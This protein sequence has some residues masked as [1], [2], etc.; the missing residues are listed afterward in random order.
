M[1]FLQMLQVNSIS[2]SYRKQCTLNAISF[3]LKSGENLSIVGESGSGKSTLL[4][5]IYGLYDLNE[6]D[7]TWN[8]KP[9]LG[10]SHNL[11]VGYDFMKYVAQDLNIMPFT[12]VNENIGHYLSNFYPKEKRLRTKELVAIVGLEGFE[13]TKVKLLSG[14]QK[15]RVAL[16]RALAKKPEILL[17]DEPFNHIDSFK[18]QTLRRNVFNYL[19]KHKITCIIA[20]HDK[21]DFLGYADK[22]I[23]LN[24]KNIVANTTPK[25]LYDNPI[26][27]FV[28]SLFD[29]Y[30]VFMPQE[31][32]AKENVYLYAHQLKIVT[33]SNIKVQVIK[34]Y[35][36]GTHY[37]IEARYNERLVYF[38]HKE[39]I[40]KNTFV[41]LEVIKKP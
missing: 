32:N 4:K 26:S 7:I 19:K 9:I 30:N 36:K 14:G 41:C 15:Q 27:E 21:D 35:F 34:S 24:N 12:T 1:L 10:P 11:V 17:L 39:A 3:S 2:F 22:I 23:V 25:Q 29:T 40:V 5:L 31:L 33:E 37:L 16:A 8:H 28:A 18:R 6:G 13:K 38:N 20:T